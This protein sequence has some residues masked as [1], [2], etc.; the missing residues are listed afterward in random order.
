MRRRRR[1]DDRDASA[2]LIALAAG[3][4]VALVAVLGIGAMLTGCATA[5]PGPSMGCLDPLAKD[6]DDPTAYPPLTAQ[7]PPWPF[8]RLLVPLPEGK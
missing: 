3:A 7:L 5:G 2:L 1:D 8:P 4:I 6:C